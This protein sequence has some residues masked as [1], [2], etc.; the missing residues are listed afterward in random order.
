MARLGSLEGPPD[1]CWL[2]V[3]KAWV[4]G[5][6]YIR[7]VS[8]TRGVVWRT[9]RSTPLWIIGVPFQDPA[10]E[11]LPQTVHI[12]HC[13][14][15]SFGDNSPF[16]RRQTNDDQSMPFWNE[17]NQIYSR[18]MFFTPLKLV[19]NEYPNPM[20]GDLYY[21]VLSITV[22]IC[23]SLSR[24]HLLSYLYFCYR[25][26]FH[27]FILFL[28]HLSSSDFEWVH[29]LLLTMK[30]LCKIVSLIDYRMWII[31]DITCSIYRLLTMILLL[32]IGPSI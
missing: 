23:Y 6:I 30:P 18:C 17:P 28:C 26:C 4:Y 11:F 14:V 27:Y 24:Y 5:I 9:C 32:S 8:M 2:S 10:W 21:H 19:P 15:L 7:P 3:C 16:Y 25:K 1:V 12:Q 20:E 13:H 29:F 31:P 22:F